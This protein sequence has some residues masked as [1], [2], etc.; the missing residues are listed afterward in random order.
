MDSAGTVLPDGAV[1]VND[2]RI[3]AVGPASSLEQRGPFERQ[4]G[5]A[6]SI[7]MPGLTHSH[8][9]TVIVFQRDYAARPFELREH[10]Y[11]YT[12]THT[13]EELYWL[14]LW[15]NLRLLKSGTTTAVGFYYGLKHLPNDLGIHPVMQ[16]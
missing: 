9:H 15:S 11:M 12:G 6:D 7:V 16:A 2:N 14:N 3:E 8:H 5:G 13:E 4:L 10:W 1:I